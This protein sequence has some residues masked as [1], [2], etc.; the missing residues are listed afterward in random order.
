MLKRHPPHS[1]Y[2]GQAI[3]RSATG[4]VAAAAIV[5][6]GSMAFFVSHAYA[7]KTA[8]TS[9]T[10]GTSSNS[11]YQQQLQL[12]LQQ[13][14]QQQQLGDGYQQQYGDPYAPQGS[15]P[16]YAPQPSYGGQPQAS[17]GGS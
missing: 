3:I 10:P 9:V 2:A 12:Q 13:Q 5:G 6:T 4:L 14:Q 11:Q 16:N 15:Q 8:G 7:G 1:R 17:S